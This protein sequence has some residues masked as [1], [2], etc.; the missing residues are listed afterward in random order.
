MMLQ[1]AFFAQDDVTTNYAVRA[2]NRSRA[3]FCLL[4]NDRRRMD[5]CVSH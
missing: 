5:L 1:P 4:I 3:E 2:N